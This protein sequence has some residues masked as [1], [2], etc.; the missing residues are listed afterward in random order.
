[1]AGRRRLAVAARRLP[2]DS[3]LLEPV[4]RGVHEGTRET[5]FTDGEARADHY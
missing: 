4:D 5:Q 2:Q 1:M 3:G